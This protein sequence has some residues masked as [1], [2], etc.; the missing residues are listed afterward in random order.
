MD[1]ISND[2]ASGPT[3]AEQF[4]AESLRI[5]SETGIPFMLAGTYAVRA[6]TEIQ[7]PTKD[8]DVFCKAGDYPRIVVHFQDRGYATEVEDER[9][10]AKVRRGEHFFDIIFNSRSAVVPVNEQWFAEAPTAR[11]YGV[12]VHIVPPTELV[13]S[14]VFVQ[15]RERYDGADIAHVILKQHEKIDW[16]RLL[17][18]MEAYWE[19]LLIHL[20]NFR[21]LYPTER[22]AVPHWLIEELLSRLAAHAELPAPRLKV[23]RGRLFSATDYEIDINEWGFADII[24]K[25]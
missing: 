24:G 18:Y 19:V 5:L 11:V 10:I 20:L 13:W 25:K 8:L 16:K 4:Y 12:D 6:Y 3:E 7:R 9:W 1:T 22:D 2:S 23:C 15:T 17:T 14:K 21:F